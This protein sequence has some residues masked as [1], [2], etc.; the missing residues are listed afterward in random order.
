MIFKWTLVTMS[1]RASNLNLLY[2][3]KLSSKF[4]RKQRW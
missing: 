4:A 3:C 1:K 2:N